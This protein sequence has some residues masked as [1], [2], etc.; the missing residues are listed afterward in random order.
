MSWC[1]GD[2]E[3]AGL[4]SSTGENIRW[5][6]CQLLQSAQAISLFTVVCDTPSDEQARAPTPTPHSS[7]PRRVQYTL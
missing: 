1:L 7:R 3:G 4:A 5:T 6:Y 2:L